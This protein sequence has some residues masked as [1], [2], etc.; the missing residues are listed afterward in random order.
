M[1]IKAIVSLN[2]DSGEAPEYSTMRG[3]GNVRRFK[4][5]ISFI[6]SDSLSQTVKILQNETKRN[7]L[8]SLIQITVPIILIS[9]VVITRL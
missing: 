9:L 6:R 7:L 4:K 8:M 5:A 3:M 2:T 1:I